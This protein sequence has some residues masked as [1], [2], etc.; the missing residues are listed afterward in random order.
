MA[1]FENNVLGLVSNDEW[2]NVG[3]NV[4]RQNDPIDS[5]FGDEKTDNITA[6]WQSI[7]S[8]YQVPMMAQFH[9]F[10]TESRQTF[11][12]P[13]DTHNIEKGLIKV[14]INQSERL[15]T[16]VRSGVRED[17]LYDY[18]LNDGIRL[19]DQVFTRT[20]VAK[21][22]LM[23]TGK[24]TIKEN[25]L[26]LTV[27]Y[28]VPNDQTAF[29]LDL[30]GSAD[31][32]SQIQAVIDA[33]TAKGVTITGMMTSRAN[34]S[35][36][37]NNAR[38]QTIVN[39]NIGAGQ[40]IRQTALDAFMS[41]EYG[42]NTIITNDLMYGADATVDTA[43][44]PT[45]TTKRYYPQDKVTFFAANPGGRLG[46][47][48]WGDPPEVEAARFYSV[49]GSAV[50]P[51]VYVMQYME[52]DPVVL[53]TKASGLFMPVLYNPNSLFIATVSDTAK[54]YTES[55]LEAMTIAQIRELAEA[56]GYTLTGTTKAE[57]IE[58]F[59]EAQGE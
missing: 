18:V 48:L 40:L 1:D 29:A 33:A 56:R 52:T 25:N 36:I 19:A 22:E 28:G 4:A 5:L 24:V 43:G 45:I 47:G 11:R 41:E 53:W 38:M 59:L 49:S 17:A 46:V 9:A 14:K 26:N 44:R 55:E 32:P 54:Q 30:S 23:A 39:G 3:F 16:L 58:S 37:R 35:K 57:L 8:E 31:I 6:K 51:F 10:D 42:I 27:D 34:L 50:S 7:A 13:V 21:N 15:R 12:V 2:L 20:K